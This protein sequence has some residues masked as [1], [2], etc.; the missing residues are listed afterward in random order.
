MFKTTSLILVA[1]LATTASAEFL[2][3]RELQSLSNTTSPVRGL[4]FYGDAPKINFLATL[5]CGACIRGGYSFCVPS[6]VPGAEP[7][8]YPVG[9]RA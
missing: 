7:S 8:S 2:Q 3:G 6:N 4:R 5:G 9:K 1:G